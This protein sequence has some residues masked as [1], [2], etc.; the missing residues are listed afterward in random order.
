MGA[1]GYGIIGNDAVLDA[2]Y[3]VQKTAGH[4]NKPTMQSDNFIAAKQL[5]EHEE[6]VLSYAKNST[7]ALHAYAHIVMKISAHMSKQMLDAFLQACLF[8]NDFLEKG[9][10][11]DKDGDQK[12]EQELIDFGKKL[13]Q[14]YDDQEARKKV[15]AEQAKEAMARQS[16]QGN[17]FSQASKQATLQQGVDFEFSK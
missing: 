12:R 14:Y 7:C 11:L 3:H 5:D 8:E 1:W 10:W 17:M 15:E 6:Q 13:Q 4:I 9:A 2:V 16:I